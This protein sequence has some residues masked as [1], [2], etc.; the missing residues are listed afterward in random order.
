MR[1]WGITMMRVLVTAAAILG[2]SACSGG[3]DTAQSTA[4]S[5]EQKEKQTTADAEGKVTISYWCMNRHDQEYMTAKINEFNAEN[6]HIYIDYQ[7]YTDNFPQMLD[8]AFSTDTA[9][10]I[11]YISDFPVYYQKGYLM[12]L[13]PYMDE[14]YRARFGEGAFVE[15]I[16]SYGDGIYSLPY[17]ASACRLFYNQDI[18]DRVGIDGPPTT[19]E[20]LIADAKLVTEQLGK[21]GIYGFAAN[22][23]SPKGSVTRT[24]DP[25]TQISGGVRSGYDFKEGRYDFSSYQP[26]LEAFQEIFAGGY[27]F[28]GCESL[29]IDP[30]RTQFA[31]GNIAMYISVTHAEPGVYASQFQTDVNWNCAPLPS[32]TGEIKGKQN[33]W[34]GGTYAGINVGTKHPQEAWEVMKFIHSDEVMADYYTLGL[35]TVMIPSVLEK[36]DPPEIVSK[37]PDLALGENDKNWPALPTNL[38]VEGKDYTDVFVECIFGMTDIEQAIADL[39]ERY[40]AAYQRMVEAGGTPISYPNFDPISLNVE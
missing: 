39:D 6:D 20:E 7:I 18:F 12:D 22:Y 17:T 15:G 8:L 30:L 27:A 34:A 4:V 16:N 40:N 24:I 21:E 5:G 38:S 33:L 26:V 23:K 36:A 2:L 35:G 29:D 11:F 13:A 28:P 3:G 31:A 25:I 10:D 37:M 9:P 1:K 32:M 19:M 14:E